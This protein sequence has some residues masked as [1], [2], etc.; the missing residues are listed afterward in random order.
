M[1][2]DLLIRDARLPEAGRDGPTVD[3]GAAGGRFPAVAPRL[4][5][6]AAEAVE[7]GGRCITYGAKPVPARKSAA[8]DAPREVAPTLGAWKHGRRC[9]TRGAPVLHR[10]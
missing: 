3:I 9:F 6:E 7:T 10:R 8:V 1:G 2:F 5:Q 4:A